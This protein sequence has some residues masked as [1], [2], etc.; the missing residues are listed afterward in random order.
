MNIWL[1]TL[2][3]LVSGILAIWFGYRQPRGKFYIFKPLTMI[4]IILLLLLGREGLSLI[5]AL[6]LAGLLFSLL[7]DILLMLPGDRFLAGLAAFLIAHLFYISGFWID[8]GAPVFW[9]ALA[10]FGLTGLT[11]WILKD[12]MGKMKI[13]A[14]GYMGVISAMVWLAWSR[15]ITGGQ[16][17]HLLAFCGAGLF[18]ISDLILAVNRFEVEFKAARALDLATYYAG[19]WLIALSVIGLDR[20]GL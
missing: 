7:G 6:I 16:L 9:P 20:W 12:G 14:L 18:M 19:Q 5:K 13:P 15:W 10:V 4:L 8:Q 2:G 3:I 11:G 17:D 1:L